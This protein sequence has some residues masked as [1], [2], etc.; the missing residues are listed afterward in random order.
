MSALCFSADELDFLHAN[1]P[2]F[3]YLLTRGWFNRNQSLQRK[4]LLVLDFGLGKDVDVM[5]DN[6]AQHLDELAT[7]TKTRPVD[8]LSMED[9]CIFEENVNHFD[10]LL[11]RSWF[12]QNALNQEKLRMVVNAGLG[13]SVN[14]LTCDDFG[15]HLDELIA[16]IGMD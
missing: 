11:G 3:G 14:V 16:S 1:V 15:E 9:L 13:Q 2:N 12:A 5:A 10:Y 7:V 8:T 4:L 6:F